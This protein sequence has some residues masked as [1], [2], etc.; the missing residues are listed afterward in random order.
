M[1]KRLDRRAVLLVW[2][3]GFAVTDLTDEGAKVEPRGRWLSKVLIYRNLGALPEAAAV[4]LVSNYQG[5]DL[6]KA[7]GS[8]G[9]RPVLPD[10][11][12]ALIDGDHAVDGR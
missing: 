8:T 9:R 5:H 11:G 4:W 2:C 1:V 6:V 3:Y 10:S 12:E 7:A